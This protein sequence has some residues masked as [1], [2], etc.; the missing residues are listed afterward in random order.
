[1]NPTHSLLL[2]HGVGGLS[3]GFIGK[4]SIMMGTYL[5]LQV[6]DFALYQRLLQ[7]IDLRIKFGFFT[8]RKFDTQQDQRYT[9]L[10]VLKDYVAS[11]K[12]V[13]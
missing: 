13:L 4:D 11:L 6:K 3:F 9:I 12:K 5:D 7:S 10:H 1:M 2:K 8:G